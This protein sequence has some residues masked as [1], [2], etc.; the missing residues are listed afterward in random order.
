MTRYHCRSL[1]LEGGIA[2]RKIGS[3]LAGTLK[4]AL[5]TQFGNHDLLI[6]HDYQTQLTRLGYVV[7][8]TTVSCLRVLTVPVLCR[9]GQHT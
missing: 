1:T 6:G 9:I 4:L 5:L 3:H 8:R 2:P 7:F